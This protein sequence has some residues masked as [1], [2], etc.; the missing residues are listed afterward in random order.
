MLRK[1]LAVV[2]KVLVHKTLLGQLGAVFFL[3][4]HVRH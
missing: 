3:F 1:T 4:L 2:Q